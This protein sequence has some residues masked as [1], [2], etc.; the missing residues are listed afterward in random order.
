MPFMALEASPLDVV[1]RETGRK[2]FRA[3]HLDPVKKTD[4]EIGALPLRSGHERPR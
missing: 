2:E 3:L 1:Q 4:T